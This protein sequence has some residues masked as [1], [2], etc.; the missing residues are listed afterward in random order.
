MTVAIFSRLPKTTKP[1]LQSICLSDLSALR[2]DGTFARRLLACE[3][4][5][6]GGENGGPVLESGVGH[7]AALAE[8]HQ[9]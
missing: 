6:R 1:S 4:I 2:G 9:I 3:D 8:S 5:L 7:A